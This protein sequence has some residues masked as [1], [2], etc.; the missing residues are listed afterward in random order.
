LF[1]QVH[2]L[3]FRQLELL[4]DRGDPIARSPVIGQQMVILQR[5]VA[6]RSVD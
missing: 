4:N 6:D 3:S 5:T 2:R 1:D